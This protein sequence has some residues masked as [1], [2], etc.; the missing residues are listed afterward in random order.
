MKYPA[1]LGAGERATNKTEKYS[2]FHT[3]GKQITKKNMKNPSSVRY[4][5]KN[6]ARKWVGVRERRL[7]VSRHLKELREAP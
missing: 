4:M 3:S 5:E 2:C 7:D 6:K 1:L